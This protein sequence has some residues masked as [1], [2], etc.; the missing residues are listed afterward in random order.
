MDGKSILGQLTIPNVVF[1]GHGLN[2]TL[3]RERVEYAWLMDIDVGC[4]E[5]AIATEQVSLYVYMQCTHNVKY[6]IEY[7]DFYHCHI[8]YMVVLK[9]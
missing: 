9:I 8:I 1:R 4:I 3:C 2:E 6:I 5:G 7:D